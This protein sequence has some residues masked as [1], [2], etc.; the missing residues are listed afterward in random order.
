MADLSAE[1]QIQRICENKK[2]SNTISD[3]LKIFESGSKLEINV[4]NS[5]L[6][7]V[8][9]YYINDGIFN[10]SYSVEDEKDAE[11]KVNL[12]LKTNYEAFVEILLHHLNHKNLSI[13]LECLMSLFNLMKVEYE[14][15]R[16]STFNFPFLF[17][18]KIMEQ[19]V[20][21]DCIEGE[22]AIKFN[23]YLKSFDI[24]Y[25][26]VKFISLMLCQKIAQK[27]NQTQNELFNVY[28]ILLDVSKLKKENKEI[29]T[30]LE[31]ENFDLTKLIKKYP[32]VFSSAWLSFMQFS[33]PSKLQKKVLVDLDKKI[34]PNLSDPKMLIDFLTDSY[35][36]GG[37]TSLLALNSLFVLIN[38][39]NLDYPDFYKK[40]YNLVDPGIFYTKYKSRFFHLL[41]L[42]LS[43]THLPVYLVAAF[44]KRLAR[45]LLY[46][47]ITDLKMVLVFIRNMFFRHP[48][49]L[50]L[51][52][53]KNM[54]SLMVDPYIY[55]EVDPQKCNAID[56][57]LWE[58][59]TLKSHYSS[60]VLKQVALFKKDLPSDEADVSDYFDFTYEDMFNSKLSLNLNKDS[61][62][63]LNFHKGN[64]IF[65]DLNE[66]M[67]VLE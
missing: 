35:N 62:P 40:L 50:I 49:S 15:K 6:Y 63:P 61:I 19:V 52:H 41:D 65:T 54:N 58:L 60:E 17:F 5:I 1:A 9:K 67:W 53:R 28:K 34:M 59:N 24:Q 8:F 36:I 64:H 11:C 29:V 48:S 33:L 31:S 55:E 26:C 38:Q 56:S 10:K 16:K 46:S 45:I 30:F 23:S 57:C 21:K 47:P 32:V 66:E 37:V 3:L 2:N 7:G 22:F 13:Q 18:Q 20:F 42:F 25:Y 27:Q 4:A 12:W 14:S 43:S 51:I 39:Y 44:I